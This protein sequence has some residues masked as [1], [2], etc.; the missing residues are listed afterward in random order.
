MAKSTVSEQ[1]IKFKVIKVNKM[2]E[3]VEEKIKKWKLEIKEIEE[4]IPKLKDSVEISSGSKFINCKIYALLSNILKN[5][6]YIV[7]ARH[8]NG[9]L[10]KYIC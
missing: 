7:I 1:E 6:C 8:I 9:Y 4:K 3:A 10:Q 2:P 5:P